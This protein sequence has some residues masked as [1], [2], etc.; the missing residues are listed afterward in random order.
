METKNNIISMFTLITLLFC[1]V[2]NVFS[3]EWEVFLGSEEFSHRDYFDE[4]IELS[5]GDILATSR[6]QYANTNGTFFTL[7][8][9][10]TLISSDGTQMCRNE[11]MKPFFSG[12]GSP[13]IFEKNGDM[14][15]LACYNPDHDINSDNY[16]KNSDNPPT[17]AILGLYKL[18]GLLNVT[19]SYEH[20]FPIDTFEMKND[21]YW[22]SYPNIF[23]GNIFMYSAFI[24]EGNIVGS[25]IKSVS[26]A[27]V[28]RGHDTIFFFKMDFD[29]NMLLKK[30]YEMHTTGGNHQMQYYRQQIIKNDNGYIVYY[31]GYSIYHHGTIE[32]YDKDFNNIATRYFD[33]PD[34][35]PSLENNLD[36]HMVV[37]SNHNTTYLAT[38]SFDRYYENFPNNAPTDRNI[39][40]Y[41]IDDNLD[42][43]TEVLPVIQYIERGTSDLDDLPCM[44]LDMAT[45]GNIYFA[46]TL[47]N[48][49]MTWGDS[50]IIIERLDSNLDTIS[51]LF[52]DDGIDIHTE[53]RCIKRTKDDGIL[54]VSK[55]KD[56]I[57]R[58]K[59]WSKITKFPA[60]AFGIDNIEEAH[61]NNLHLAVAYPNPGGDVL[62]IRTGLRNAVLTVYDLQGRKIHEE[63][64]T[65][66][67]TSVDASGWQSGTYVWKLKT[68]NGKL[69]IEEG[70]WVK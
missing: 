42:N 41:E 49:E 39:R 20:I 43:S 22:Q 10:L 18:D 65:D 5:N 50:W 52:Y 35:L 28:P 40:L 56:I 34:F 60:S 26:Y 6:S 21:M 24:D 55:S 33:V 62:N 8:P 70:K 61:A 47:N 27:D 15:M 16:F 25:Y 7:H 51:T 53:A 9:A 19:K 54:L 13:Y 30:G 64:I 37:R 12:I 44:S 31:R 68:E 4:V 36:N 38:T 45:D 48:G 67:V 29:G 32:Y 1:G 3:Q 23:C 57:N 59:R 11:Y 66:D 69:K 2:V 63:E 14:Y 46:Y 58:S 17:D